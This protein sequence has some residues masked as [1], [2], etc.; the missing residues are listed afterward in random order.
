MRGEK[1]EEQVRKATVVGGRNASHRHQC[2]FGNKSHPCCRPLPFLPFYLLLL[3]LL[4]PPGG[5][6][7]ERVFW[8]Y[9]ILF[10]LFIYCFGPAVFV[11]ACV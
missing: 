10:Y 9:F 8:F 1:R 2:A 7:E 3:L 5:V 4:P 11:D 6:R